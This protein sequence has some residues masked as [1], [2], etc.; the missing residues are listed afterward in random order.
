M[1][2]IGVVGATGLVGQKILTCLA[3]EGLLE[4]VHITLFASEKNHGK[5]I[6][7]KSRQLRVIKLDE[8]ALKKKFDIV[9]FSAGEDVSKKWAKKFVEK[10]AFVIDNSNAFRRC[11]EVPLVCPEINGGL[12]SSKSRLIS[13]PNCSTIQLVL[14]LDALLQFGIE[15]VV[16]S[17]YQSVSGAG[18]KAIADL[19]NGTNFEICEGIKN[20]IVSKIGNILDTGFCVEEDKIMFETSKIL[21]KT[22][23]VSATTV[24]VPVPY[25]H[26][27]SV[28]VKLKT[29]VDLSVIRARLSAFGIIVD[30][31]VSLPLEV[32]D[33]NEVHVCRLRKQSKTELLFVVVAD[34]LRRGAAYNAVKISAILLEKFI[35]KH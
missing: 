20:N 6:H 2:E 32:A 5:M 12:V 21:G 3:E 23:D 27:E 26:T 25:C 35:K 1:I 31:E 28:Y 15:K 34:N 14:V 30:D 9:F 22:L 24:R 7:V 19:E 16:V 29:E 18:K 17:T 13:N 33:T 10:G 11:D 4:K 8:N